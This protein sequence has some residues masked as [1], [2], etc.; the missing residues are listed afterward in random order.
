M[1]LLH[2]LCDMATSSPLSA[3]PSDGAEVLELLATAEALQAVSRGLR[4]NKMR[5]LRLIRIAGRRGIAQT[6]LS[7]AMGL[8]PAAISRLCDELE[9]EGLVL[10]EAHPLDR[11]MKTLHL[12][13]QGM[14]QV[15][16]CDRATLA[17]A[18]ACIPTTQAAGVETIH[19]LFQ[20]MVAQMQ[21]SQ[22]TAFCQQCHLGGC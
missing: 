4:D 3:P 19:H 18:A 14:A 12:S 9:V 5:A 10:R 21:A 1:L 2:G 17:K 11:R 6:A 15:D 7:A 16:Y 13:D 20:K 8:S 22:C